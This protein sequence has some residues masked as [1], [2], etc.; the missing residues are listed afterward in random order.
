MYSPPEEIYLAQSADFTSQTVFTNG[1]NG[2]SVMIT[3]TEADTLDCDAIIQLSNDAI[4]WVSLNNDALTLNSVDPVALFDYPITGA[5]F[6]RVSFVFAAG[7]ADF[8]INPTLK[9]F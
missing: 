7:S 1:Y 5:M 2:F 8:K 4:N 3:V 9:D 6:Y